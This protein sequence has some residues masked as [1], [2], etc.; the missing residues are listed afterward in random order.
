MPYVAARKA[1]DER[2]R[3]LSVDGFAAITINPPSIVGAT[4]ASLRRFS[5]LF[6]W[7]RGELEQPALF[8][9]PGGTN[10]MSV[11]SLAEAVAGALSDGEPGRAYLVGDE[12][13]T[14]R[15]YFQLIADVAGS[16]KVIEERDE[17]HPYQPDRFIVQGRGR[18]IRYEPDPAEVALLGYRRADVRTALEEIAAAV[19]AA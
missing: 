11:R 18:V 3:A 15:E 2:T 8:A 4:P 10:Y 5:R 17:A 1:A 19:A 6:A 14:Y 9:P 16:T 12:N 13:L 7:A